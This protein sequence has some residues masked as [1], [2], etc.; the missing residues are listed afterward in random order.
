M[1]LAVRG[2]FIHLMHRSK[3]T[4]TFLYGIEITN[5]ELPAQTSLGVAEGKGLHN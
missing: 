1:D 3:L 4:E 2:W 5:Q